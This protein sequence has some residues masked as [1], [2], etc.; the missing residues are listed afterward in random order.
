MTSSKHSLSDPFNEADA[1]NEIKVKFSYLNMSQME[2]RLVVEISSE[3]LQMI[4]TAE[5]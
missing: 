1:V 4:D 2:A 5:M 3:N